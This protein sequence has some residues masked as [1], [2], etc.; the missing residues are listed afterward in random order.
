MFEAVRKSKRIAQV[1]L[2]I[3][4]IPFAFFGMDAYFSDGPGGGEL[5]TVGGSKITAAEFDRALREQQDRLRESMGE[6]VDRAMLD[7]PELRRAVLDNLVNQRVL[8]LH[9]AK[10][11]MV[12][13]QQQLQAVIS[14]L[15]AFQSEGRFSLERY[16]NV[17][18][19]QGMSPAVFEARLGQD[20]RVQQLARAVSESSFAA[21]ASARRFLAAQ[22]EGREIRELR[23][24]PTDVM[25]EVQLADAAAQRYYDANPA[26]FERPARVRAQYAVFDKQALLDQVT[27]SD[28]A[29]QQ[30]Y[31]ANQD[32]FGQPEERRARHILIPA[33]SSAE[34]KAQARDKAAAIL[35]KLRSEPGR[36]EEL[37]KAESQDPGSAERGG[38][39]GFFGRGAMVKPFEDAAFGL[40]K[41]QISDLVKSDFGFHIIEVTDI[42]P[43]T[44]RPLEAVREEV[45]AELK[46]QEASRRFAEQADQFAN[47]AYEQADSLQPVADLLKLEIRESDWI[48]RGATKIGPFENE[49]LV[50]ALFSDDAVKHKRNVEAVEVASG[51]LVSA[52]VL[53][54]EPAQ[55]LSFE[56]VRPIIEQQLRAEEAARLARE[57]GEAALAAANRGEEVAG[58]WSAP[59]TVQRGN[60][61]LP[62]AAMGAVFQA[63]T[64]KLPVHVGAAM[65]GGN[66]AVF[67]IQKVERPE[68]AA[69]DS[70]VKAIAEQYERLMAER[71]FSAFLAA[72]RERYEVV[73]NA[74]ALA[75]RQQ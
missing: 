30:F 57:R 37:A 71:D 26:R 18:R 40:D 20:L 9:S 33:G 68:L 72:L 11:R 47:T 70:R 16:E 28:E 54:F 15:P 44:V 1:I 36:F 53:E 73:I 29:V 55:R 12:V 45:V 6:E 5:A 66:Y 24:A 38:D 49:K 8:A 31:A 42:R 74:E 75:P 34:E 4:I 48:E 69:D 27:V 58:E 39:L 10:N 46:G 52:R 59:R 63:P 62:A 14:S 50:N 56:S 67:R 7:S 17:L 64:G 2:A 61:A 35:A 19:A 60:P 3:I 23:F 13:T 65:P 51:T 32:R 41:G 22:L 21:T 43:A 25:G